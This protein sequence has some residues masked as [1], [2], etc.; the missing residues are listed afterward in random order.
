MSVLPTARHCSASAC[1]TGTSSIAVDDVRIDD[2]AAW[3]IV[4][5]L[6]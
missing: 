3:E 6:R 1:G 5:D 4:F 2:A